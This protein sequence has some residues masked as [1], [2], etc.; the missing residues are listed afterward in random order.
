[1]IQLSSNNKGN[2]KK[3][4]LYDFHYL[5]KFKFTETTTA[6]MA[7]NAA[8][9]TKGW[10]GFKTHGIQLL[11]RSSSRRILPSATGEIPS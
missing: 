5:H 6:E 8:A 10:L 3:E 2:C 11:A 4:S 9:G 7:P 1:M